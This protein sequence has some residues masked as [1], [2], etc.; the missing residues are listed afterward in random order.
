MAKKLIFVAHSDICMDAKP[1]THQI[2]VTNDGNLNHGKI[3]KFKGTFPEAIKEGKR[4]LM[5]MGEGAVLMTHGASENM[6]YFINKNK[7]LHYA[8]PSL[9]KNGKITYVAGK[10][11]GGF[12]KTPSR[13]VSRKQRA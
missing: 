3:T 1:G 11:A 13:T 8:Y 10:P 9:L 2:N 4:R 7:R 12:I 5:N 6:T